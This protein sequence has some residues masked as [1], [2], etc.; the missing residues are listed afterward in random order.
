M[1]KNILKTNNKRDSEMD[2][3]QTRLDTNQKL[4]IKTTKTMMTEIIEYKRV[5]EQEIIIIL[6]DFHDVHHDFWKYGGFN[7]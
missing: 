6:K 1:K 2:L 3:L 7:F 4:L 5:S